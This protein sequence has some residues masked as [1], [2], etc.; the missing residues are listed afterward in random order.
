MI[1]VVHLGRIVKKLDFATDDANFTL[2][3]GFL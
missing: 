2:W 1:R 3:Q